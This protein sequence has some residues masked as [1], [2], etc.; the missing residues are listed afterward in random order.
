MAESNPPSR[1]PGVLALTE[2]RSHLAQPHSYAV[3]Y[4]R[5]SSNNTFI[6]QPAPIEIE[7]LLG[8]FSTWNIYQTLS[9][10]VQ[11]RTSCL[12]KLAVLEF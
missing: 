5:S 7:S 8:D 4:V 2:R 6:K 3:G 1:E 9:Q 12:V 10:N 11:C